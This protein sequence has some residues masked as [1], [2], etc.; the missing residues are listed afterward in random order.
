MARS[1]SDAHTSAETIEDLEETLAFLVR[2]LEA[3]QRMRT[4]PMER[5]H[6]LLIRLIEREGPQTVVAAAQHLLLD[7]STVTRQVAVMERRGLVEKTSHPG[8]A[9]ATVLTVTPAGF[10]A[11]RRMREERLK[12]IENLFRDWPADDRANADAVLKRLNR[13]LAEIVRTAAG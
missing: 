13:S 5:A 6:Y 11:A 10:A 1:R 3:A 8:D 2:G 7:G 9:R 12:R 4:Y